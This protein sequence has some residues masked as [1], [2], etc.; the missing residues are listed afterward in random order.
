ME[1]RM[2]NEGR[3]D[4]GGIERSRGT[5][6]TGRMEGSVDAPRSLGGREAVEIAKSRENGR[7]GGSIDILCERARRKGERVER[8]LVVLRGTSGRVV[9]GRVT[10]AERLKADRA[11]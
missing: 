6:R 1:V 9:A 10:D 3:E 4:I 8:E 7:A 2:R 5:G 11:G